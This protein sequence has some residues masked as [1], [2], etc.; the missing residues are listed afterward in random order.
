MITTNE[1]FH[2]SLTYVSKDA[3]EVLGTS[4]TGNPG[5]YSVDFP[6]GT[7]HKEENG[8]HRFTLPCGCRLVFVDRALMGANWASKTDQILRVGVFCQEHHGLED[9]WT[10]NDTLETYEG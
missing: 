9:G 1:I 2:T 4:L 6:E 3:A 8:I 7:T 5:F 10:R